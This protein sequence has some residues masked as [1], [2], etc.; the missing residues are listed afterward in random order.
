[1]LRMHLRDDLQEYH[2]G[3]LIMI[4]MFIL[5]SSN[6][7]GNYDHMLHSMC[8]QHEQEMILLQVPFAISMNHS[9]YLMH[10]SHMPT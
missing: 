4:R 1:M 5:L 9:K 2:H 7:P 6:T 10:I 8:P 3:L